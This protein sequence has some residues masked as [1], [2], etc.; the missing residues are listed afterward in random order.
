MTHSGV[1]DGT[2]SGCFNTQLVQ[3][4]GQNLRDLKRYIN[5]IYSSL[6]HEHVLTLVRLNYLVPAF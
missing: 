3:A 2:Y 6:H 1:S 5:Y 4:N